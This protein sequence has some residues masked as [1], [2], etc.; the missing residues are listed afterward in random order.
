MAAD[1]DF[2]KKERTTVV[3]LFKTFKAPLTTDQI[4]ARMKQFVKKVNS[5][6]LHDVLEETAFELLCSADAIKNRKSFLRSLEIV[7]NADGEF[8]RREQFA[9]DKLLAALDSGTYQAPDISSLMDEA[10][11]AQRH[12]EELHRRQEEEESRMKQLYEEAQKPLDY[13]PRVCRKCKREVESWVKKEVKLVRTERRYEDRG[14]FE[15][16]YGH[17]GSWHEETILDFF[18][19]SDCVVTGRKTVTRDICPACRHDQ[20]KLTLQERLNAWNY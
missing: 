6:N 17:E 7:A 5:S 8:D 16:I 20:S 9:V 1:G 18:P 4:N 3:E 13:R 12:Q 2:S 19:D 14:I 15:H 10:D 11:E